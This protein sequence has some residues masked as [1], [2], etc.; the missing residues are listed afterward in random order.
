ML[1]LW[2]WENEKI[3]LRTK[4]FSQDVY[5]VSFSPDNEGQ[6]ASSGTGHIKF[7]KMASTFTGL[8]LQGEIGKFGRSDLSDI[9]GFVHLPDGK[10]LSG[11]E[12]GI[13]LLWEGHF[14]KC[15]IWK[16]GRTPC[17]QGM[18]EVMFLEGNELLTAGH[19]GYLK[20]WD[21]EALDNSDISEEGGLFELEPLREI[22]IG[23]KVQIKAMLKGH[24]HWL[25]QDA[26]G[27][28]WKV[29]F[30]TFEITKV[31]DFH[32]GAISGLD[33]CPVDHVAATSGVDGVVR[34]VDYRTCCPLYFSLFPFPA[35]TLLWS[36]LAVDPDGRTVLVGFEDGV[37]RL[38]LRCKDAFKVIHVSKPHSSRITCA[39]YSPDGKI[40]ATGST[41][42]TVFFLL[43]LDNYSPLGFVRVEGKIRDIS[44]SS[45]GN[46]LLVFCENGKVIELTLPAS[47]MALNVV[48]DY[49]IKLSTKTYTLTTS[50][51]GLSAQE[52]TPLPSIMCGSYSENGKSFLVAMDDNSGAILECRMDES[53]PIRQIKTH[54][55]TCCTFSYS[56]RQNFLLSGDDNGIIHIHSMADLDSVSPV[57]FHGSSSRI[58]R[59]VTSFDDSHLLS[60]SEDGNFFIGRLTS[61]DV[62]VKSSL[63]P[64][65]ELEPR[66]LHPVDDITI[67]THYSIQEAKLRDEQDRL[68]KLAEEKKKQRRA[69]VEA[70]RSSFAALIEENK[71]AHTSE[72]FN[73]NEIAIDP[74][75]R[76]TIED[77]VQT[78]LDLT[79]KELAWEREH[80]ELLLQK[81]K[82]RY[83]D[84]IEAEKVTLRAF[85]VG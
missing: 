37:I 85:K 61:Q 3:L 57:M 75:L 83:L 64:K 66:P 73:R 63:L 14:V 48:K 49:E 68:I 42:C 65:A 23:D 84:G 27:A 24:D 12:T 70:L 67:A 41:D 29:A 20:F 79:R 15:E 10:V 40:L 21:F 33:V 28:L 35:T 60:A 31:M 55:T 45:A 76:A 1:T 53:T 82:Q 9:V 26:G 50:R 32:A 54:A 81:L 6:L 36:P 7:W 56:H 4:A 77:S 17:H 62:V 58:V 11:T 52:E 25:L 74:N 39:Q 2:D 72:Q 71:I 47:F 44:W 59:V 30:S 18:V 34:L 51:E 8:K 46:Y 43:A 69:R 13:L 16:T 5:K 78:K 80:K 38:L 22:K 19:D